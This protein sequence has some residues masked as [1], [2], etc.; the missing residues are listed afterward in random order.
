ME[1]DKEVGSIHDRIVNIPISFTEV[2][3]ILVS[4]IQ[5]TV[6]GYL[7]VKFDEHYTDFT[8]LTILLFIATFLLIIV[9][10][11][12]YMTGSTALRFKPQLFPDSLLIFALG[13]TET[14]AI[15]HIFSELYLWCYSMAAATFVSGLALLNGLRNARQHPAN[16]IIFQRLGY[17]P[18]VIQILF[19]ATAILYVLLGYA[20]YHSAENGIAYLFLILTLIYLIGSFKYWATIVHGPHKKE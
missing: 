2:Y 17:W 9:V 16:D 13:F 4:I 11:N 1:K 10:W 6:F 18:R 8:H 5:A 14:L 19:F 20:S 3:I 12:Q 7:I 15:H